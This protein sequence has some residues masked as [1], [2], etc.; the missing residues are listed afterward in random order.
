MPWT[1]KDAARHTRKARTSKQREQWAAVANAVLKSTDDEGRAVRAANAAVA[2]S[3][4][5][6]RSARV[7]VSVVQGG[8]RPYAG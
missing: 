7:P 1:A 3:G 5:K 4:K 2:K 8:L 6:R